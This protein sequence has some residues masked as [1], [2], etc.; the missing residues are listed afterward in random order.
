LVPKFAVSNPAEAVGFLGR[1]IL[2]T[3][4]F[5]GEV[6]PSVPCRSFTACKR[7][8]N[9]TWKS[10]FRQNL[11]DISRPQFHLPLLG[12]LAWWH[13]WRHLVAKVGTSNPD[14]TVI[15][16]RL[17]CVVG[18]LI[19]LTN[20]MKRSPSLEANSSSAS[21]EIPRVLWNLKVH[22]RL[23]KSPKPAPVLSHIS[24][25]HASSPYS[26]NP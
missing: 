21:H 14:R 4:Y 19:K 9:V 11:P 22:Y 7:S 13:A 18:K 20:S 23:H 8:L 6:K 25:F 5:G 16:K 1:K 17:Q 10:A 26:F 2:S 12:A 15:L 3:P 24:P